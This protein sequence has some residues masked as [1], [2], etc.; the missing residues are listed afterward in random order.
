MTK[1]VKNCIHC[2]EEMVYSYGNKNITFPFCNNPKCPNY[3][4]LQT[5]MYP[6][7]AE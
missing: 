4:L 7:E 3:G 6:K 2:Q 1:E 5:G